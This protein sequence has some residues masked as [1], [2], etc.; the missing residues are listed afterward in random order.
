[1]ANKGKLVTLQVYMEIKI[2]AKE[3]YLTA[4]QN[5][6]GTNIFRNLYAEVGSERKDLL[7][8]GELSC[9]LFT[10]S[11]LYLF[12]MITSVHATVTSTVKDLENFGWFE[13]PETKKGAVIVWKKKDLGDGDPHP[14]IGFSLGGTRA[15]SNNKT[16]GTPIEH[17]LDFRG[18]EIEKILW[19]TKLD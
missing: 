17:A 10:S 11:L 16:E 1:M 6:V 8:D 5:S 15:I 14:H 9:A 2:L 3:N 19:N 13:I 12:K 18:R 4:I 7:N